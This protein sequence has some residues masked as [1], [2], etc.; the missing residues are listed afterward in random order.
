MLAKLSMLLTALP[1]AIYPGVFMAG[2][3]GLAAQPNPNADPTRLLVAKSFMVLSL[4]YPV[5][6]VV[7]CALWAIGRDF[8]GHLIVW[9]NLLLCA[10][11][12]A[13]WY[14]MST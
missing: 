7:G 4:L 10:A 3:M 1:I 11:L 8:A 2:I 14:C 9:G 6:W 13:A 5:T 12:F